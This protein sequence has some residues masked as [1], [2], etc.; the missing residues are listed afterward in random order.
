MNSN[1]FCSYR[2]SYKPG[3]WILDWTMPWTGLWTRFKTLGNEEFCGL[4]NSLQV[5]RG[6]K[7]PSWGLRFE[8]STYAMICMHA[9][10]WGGLVTMAVS[11]PVM[12]LVPWACQGLIYWG[13]YARVCV[14]I[15]LFPTKGCL[16]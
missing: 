14:E 11:G 4:L 3:P 12:Y 15:R 6:R 9:T 5:A 1:R 2:G 16:V 8:N 10:L 7:E 13:S